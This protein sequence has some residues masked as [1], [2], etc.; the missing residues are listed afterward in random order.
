MPWHRAGDVVK[1]LAKRFNLSPDNYSVFKVWD[2]ELGRL[3][4][5]L[6]LVGKKNK[7]LLVKPHSSIY[8]QELVL[9]KKEIINKINQY[10]HKGFIEDIKIV[11]KDVE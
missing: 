8:K 7:T 11:R 6:V 9:R 10:Y 2:K 3:A 1:V 5:K 4:A